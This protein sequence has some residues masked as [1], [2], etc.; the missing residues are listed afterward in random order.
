VK[1]TCE[2]AEDRYARPRL[3]HQDHNMDA[4]LGTAQS[5]M[6]NEHV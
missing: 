2:A 5:I 6:K 3:A 4:P 1:A